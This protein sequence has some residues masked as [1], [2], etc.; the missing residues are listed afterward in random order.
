M[1]LS[2]F[3]SEHR[4]QIIR[5][6]RTGIYKFTFSCRFRIGNRRLYHMTGRIQLMPLEQIVEAPFSQDGIVGIEIS[7]RFLCPDNQVDRSIR[8]LLQFLVRLFRKRICCRLQPFCNVCIL[9]NRPLVSPLLEAARNPEILHTIALFRSW[10]TVIDQ[11][12]FEGKNHAL[13]KTD[14]FIPELIMNMDIPQ[15]DVLKPLLIHR[16]LLFLRLPSSY[17]LKASRKATLSS[18]IS[19]AAV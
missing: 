13:H 14:I 19:L 4:T 18:G 1:Y 7:I 15:G 8:C 16:V 17:I 9:K 10:N 6:L 12:P 3:W 11:I 5:Q 2:L